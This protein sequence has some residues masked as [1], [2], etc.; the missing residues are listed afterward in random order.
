[1]EKKTT[2]F[3]RLK[4]FSLLNLP[5]TKGRKGIKKSSRQI[6]KTAAWVNRMVDGE[7]GPAR[8]WLRRVPTA[9]GDVIHG[10]TYHTLSATGKLWYA[11]FASMIPAA[12][13]NEL[14]GS[15][16]E[17]GIVTLA[18]HTLEFLRRQGL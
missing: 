9:Q 1:M 4:N 2:E 13:Y 7:D 12:E 16:I 10:P 18:E 6:G 15:A 8:H 14:I 17:A 5:V 3:E 11:Q